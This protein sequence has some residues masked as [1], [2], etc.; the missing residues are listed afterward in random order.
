MSDRYFIELCYQDKVLDKKFIDSYSE[1]YD[2]KSKINYCEVEENERI[3][4]INEHFNLEL[5]NDMIQDIFVR[6]YELKE[7]E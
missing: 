1:V 4:C 5:T 7:I 3:E 6:I 2:I